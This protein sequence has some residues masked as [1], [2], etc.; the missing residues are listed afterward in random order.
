M[1]L[2]RVVFASVFA[3]VSAL[4][5]ALVFSPAL[6]VLSAC[7]GV[8]DEEGVITLRASH[9]WPGGK[10]D[11]RDEMV[12]R[13]ARSVDEANVGLEIKVYPGK[14]L[15]KPKDQW[16]AA[17]KGQL[18]MAALPLAYAGG[19]H[20]EFNLTLMPGLVKDHAHAKRMND[21]PFMTRIKAI[22]DQAGVVLLADAWLAGGFASREDCIQE[23][24]SVKGKQMRAAGKAFEEM[25]AGAGASI[26]SMPSSEIY[27]AM[28]TGV[29]DAAITS[30]SSFVSYRLYEQVKCVTA[31]GEHALWFMYEPILISKKSFAKLNEKQRAAL[32]RAAQ[33]AEDYAYQAAIAADVDMVSVFREHGVKVVTMT[34]EQVARWKAIAARTSYKVFAEQVPG[35]RE[36]LE[37]AQSV[38]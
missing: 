30:S 6:L 28:Q 20:P 9:Q 21:S 33:E 13:M 1:S 11:L 10:G 3:S 22:A 37:M 2:T 36:L 23:P 12:Q 16:G 18:D 35:G 5:S 25:L 29:L 34:A 24:D 8:G 15:F 7:N 14:S 27:S 17:V 19:R 38:K 32:L 31:P 4:V 26:A